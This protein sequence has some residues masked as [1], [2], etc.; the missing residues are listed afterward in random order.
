MGT[1]RFPPAFKNEA[2]RLVTE[3]AHWIWPPEQ[4]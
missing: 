3:V 1:P 4:R 2:V